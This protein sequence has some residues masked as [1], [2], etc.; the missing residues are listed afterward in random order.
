M[1]CGR[2][3]RLLARRLR[4]ASPPVKEVGPTVVLEAALDG[5]QGAGSRP[6]PSAR[7]NRLPTICLRSL[8]AAPEPV[9]SSAPEGCA[10]VQPRGDL[11]TDCLDMRKKVNVHIGDTLA[12]MENRGNALDLKLA[13]NKP[14]TIPRNRRRR[15]C[16]GQLVR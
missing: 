7:L 1:H 6:R 12:D 11:E 9:G 15:H 4:A 14:L 3:S 5:E 10:A 8:S 16:R 13:F 2:V